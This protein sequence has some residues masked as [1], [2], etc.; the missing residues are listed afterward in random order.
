M[1][2]TIVCASCI[3]LKSSN[4][5]T[6]PLP[7]LYSNLSEDKDETNLVQSYMDPQSVT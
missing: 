4:Y 2:S 3:A 5:L 6:M 7:L 1:G